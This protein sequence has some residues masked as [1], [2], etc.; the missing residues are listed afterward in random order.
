MKIGKQITES[1]HLHLDMS[2]GGGARAR[3]SPLL[4]SVGIPEPERRLRRVPA[5]AVGRHAPARHHRHR[6][7]LRP[8]AAVRRRA[9]DRARRDRAG[10]DP[11][12]AQ[13]AAARPQHGDDARHPRPRR[14]GRPHRR[15]RRDVRRQ[16]RRAGADARSLFSEHADAL[17]RGAAEVASRSSTTRS[18]T[19]LAG[20][21]R[22]PA[23]PR[24]PAHGLPVRPRCPYAQDRCR[25]EEPPL[26]EAEIPGH[27]FACWYP[28]GSPE[29]KMRSNA[30]GAAAAEP[31]TRL[32]SSRRPPTA[33]ARGGLMAGTRHCPPP[34]LRR[35]ALLRV[36][37][38]VVEFPV[39]RTGLKVNAVSGISFDVLARRDPRSR[40]RVGLRQVD[41]R[42]GDHAAPPPDGRHASS[43]TARSSPRSMTSDVRKLRTDDADDLPGPDLVA[44]PTAQGRATSWPSRSTIWKLGTEARARRTRCDRCSRTSAS[45]PTSPPTGGR[46][47]S[48]AVSAS[49]SAIARALVLDPKLIICDEP[50]S[51]L[52]VS[53]AGADPEPARGPEGAATASR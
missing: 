26:V 15:D 45:I 28:V 8:D 27:T 44:E 52:D 21:R 19:R 3:P 46:T 2:E 47:S 39:G 41:D 12:P 5:P 43:S 20:H 13:R 34:R 4:R 25:E 36:E 23:R 11:R 18:H 51:A 14:R 24:Q 40:R 53:G 42:P 37:D 9:D 7:R 22:A 10:A 31:R 35:D 50:V 16:D 1:L 32:G 48:P 29:G 49:A 38:L 33:D 17:H 30:T 6:P